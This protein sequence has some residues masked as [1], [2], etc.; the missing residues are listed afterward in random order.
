MCYWKVESYTF[1][2][3]L[4]AQQNSIKQEPHESHIYFFFNVKNDRFFGSSFFSV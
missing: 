3:T 2:S 1:A 4:R